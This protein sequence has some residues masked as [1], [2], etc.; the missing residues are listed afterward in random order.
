[1]DKPN[2]DK[3]YSAY[4]VDKIRLYDKNRLLRT[5]YQVNIRV[6]IENTVSSYQT[7][8]GVLEYNTLTE[9]F[10]DT[11]VNYINFKVIGDTLSVATNVPERKMQVTEKMQE[12]LIEHKENNSN[13]LWEVLGLLNDAQAKIKVDDYLIP[14]NSIK[15]S[16]STLTVYVSYH[17]GT[18]WKSKRLI[19]YTSQLEMEDNLTVQYERDGNAQLTSL[20]EHY[21]VDEDNMVH[22]S[23]NLNLFDIL[24]KSK[25]DLT[26]YT[27]GENLV[28]DCS[29]AEVMNQWAKG[30]DYGT[31]MLEYLTGIEQIELENTH[32]RGSRISQRKNLIL[33]PEHTVVHYK[34][35]LE[36]FDTDEA[37][38]HILDYADNKSD[39]AKEYITNLLTGQYGTSRSTLGFVRGILTSLAITEEDLPDYKKIDN[40]LTTIKYLAF[41]FNLQVYKERIHMLLHEWRMPGTVGMEYCLTSGNTGTHIMV[42]KEGY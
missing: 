7:F 36:L 17:T 25:D 9:W 32:Y 23:F 24:V 28:L 34:D 42:K 8:M 31:R 20:A 19:S 37:T 39:L 2:I 3:V 5:L 14:F 10:K 27:V 40:S 30:I 1:M 13:S 29:Q 18:Q 35:V 11:E 26:T 21:T 33:A 6:P 12:F 38:Q 4:I 41:K 22:A 15:F 16:G